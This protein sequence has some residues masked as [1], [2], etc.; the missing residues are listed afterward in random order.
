MT[1]ACS[2]LT[3]VPG[4]ATLL[5][6]CLAHAVPSVHMTTHGAMKADNSQTT[7]TTRTS[8]RTRAAVAMTV[9]VTRVLSDGHTKP[10]TWQLTEQSGVALQIILLASVPMPPLG[11][12]SIVV[13]KG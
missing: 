13:K 4:R 9:P 3:E 10:L 2:K 7:A 5:K 12:A 11:L 8:I 6:V 1:L